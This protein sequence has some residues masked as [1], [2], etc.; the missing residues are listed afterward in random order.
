MAGASRTRPQTGKIHDVIQVFPFG[1]AFSLQ[2]RIGGRRGNGRHFH[3]LWYEQ[4]HMACRF[5]GSDQRIPP[6]AVVAIPIQSASLHAMR[7]SLMVWALLWRMH[8]NHQCYSQG[9]VVLQ[10]YLLGTTGLA[11]RGRIRPVTEASRLGHLRTC[12]AQQT[13]WDTCH[14][15]RH[16]HNY[17]SRTTCWTCPSLGSTGRA[18]SP[19]SWQLGYFRDAQ[20]WGA[21][22]ALYD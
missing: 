7:E 9:Q 11:S 17:C 18:N 8:R 10:S 5:A 19:K 14:L 13:A 22:S 4:M 3:I 2:P 16:R 1:A 20:A 21:D 15:G 6:W 12:F